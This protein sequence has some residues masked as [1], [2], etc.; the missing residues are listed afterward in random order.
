MAT[1][2]SNLKIMLEG[3][4]R[5]RPLWS[6]AS[7]KR[8]PLFE[9]EVCII[10][11]GIARTQTLQFGGEESILGLVGPMMPVA[12][13]FTM[14]TPYEFY[15]L[16]HVDLLRLKWEEAESSDV[17]MRELN[18]SLMQRLCHTEAM[19]AL[20]SQR[21]TSERLIGFL[22]FLAQEYGKRTSQGVRIE[23]HLTHQQIADAICTTRVTITRL[24][25]VLRKASLIRIG[26][27]RYFYV[28][29]DLA[30]NHD[31]NFSGMV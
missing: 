13:R 21:Q 31:L 28:M 16:T 14:L 9:D 27:D 24:L 5:G 10:Y 17:I 6:Y 25:G 8:I 30:S 7:S 15:A 11:R 26:Q 22:A 12:H 23:A 3:L 2:V 19:L 4:Y 18:R 1:N 20:R 29:D